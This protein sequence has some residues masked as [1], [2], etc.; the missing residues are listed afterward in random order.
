MGP[1]WVDLTGCELDAEE[2]E[3][4]QHPNVGGVILFARNYHDSE[5]LLALCQS[6][7]KASKGKV[8]IGV[9]QEGGLVQRFRDGFTRIPEAQKFAQQTNG[10][11]RAQQAGWLMAAELVAH[12]VDLSFAPVLDKGHK[13]Q[14]IRSRSFSD[15]IDTVIS[16]SAAYIR[17][18]RQIGMAATGK[19]FPGHGGVV[20]DSH[21]ATPI[22]GRTNIIEQDM[23]IFQSHIDAGLL[24]AMMPA[25]VIYPHYD[26]RPA[27]GSTF[28]L[29]Q[30]LRKQLGFKGIIFSDD[31]NM[32]GAAVM[33]GA[34]ERAK[35]AL[36]A[37][38]D[39]LLLCNNRKRTIEVLD[40]LPMISVDQGGKLFKRHSFSLS[41]LH[42]SPDWKSASEA[43][44]RIAEA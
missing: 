21:L 26:E 36:E 33:G 25:H 37:G 32:E 43:M 20:E 14:A 27:C 1:L 17:G 38:C 3:I 39:M 9:D 5:Q 41:E 2:K 4:L 42:A 28:W 29:Q 44:K 22:D 18:M 8:L 11:L 35:Q 23:A 15:D 19:H 30:V 13:S 40:A 34:A 31:L 16:L 24:D 12:D 6:I 7:R 10:P